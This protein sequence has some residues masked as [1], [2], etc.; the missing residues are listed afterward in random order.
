MKRL[1]IFI[2]MVTIMCCSVCGAMTSVVKNGS[3]ENDG[4]YMD[5]TPGSIP[6]YWCD[7]SY[8]T[9]DFAGYLDD[10]YWKT[11]GTYSLTF[12]NFS[13]LTVQSR[14]ASISQSVYLTTASQIIFDTYLFATDGNWTPAKATAKV[15]I[16]GNTVWDSNGLT[17]T[18]GEFTGQIVIDVNEVYKDAY[19][20]ILSF[21]LVLNVS[22]V[23]Y[24]QY[25]A[26]WDAIGF[27][28]SC[29]AAGYLP[30]DFTHDCVVDINDLAIFAEG[31]LGLNG[32]DLTGDN[33]VN[34]AD[35]DVLGLSWGNDTSGEVFIPPAGFVFLEGDINDDGIVDFTDFSILANNWQGEGGSC[36]RED[37]NESGLI[38]FE[39]LALLAGQWQE[40][41]D[42]YGL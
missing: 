22:T 1:M 32:P 26:Q 2:S 28:A 17:Y 39:D 9:N 15:L 11:D 30:A 36:V 42:L 21:Q 34:F 10:Y 25:Y 35:F 13:K 7:V 24:I 16:D 5:V 19:P 6:K 41:G 29:G 33:E 31:W 38:D 12:A 14:T 27:N 37:I 23:S 40:I 4:H 8:N 3:F 18:N 20:H